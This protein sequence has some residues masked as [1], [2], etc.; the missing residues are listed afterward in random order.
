MRVLIPL[1]GIGLGTLTTAPAGAG[2]DYIVEAENRGQR[3]PV[4]VGTVIAQGIRDGDVCRFDDGFTVDVL[5]QGST[6]ELDVVTRV[7]DDRAVVVSSS[8][9]PRRV[10]MLMHDG[11]AVEPPPES[12]PGSRFR[13]RRSQRRHTV[14]GERCKDEPSF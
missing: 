13:N 1:I 10:Q 8:A 4:N 7:S 9:L 11:D 3:I 6:D 12:S 2:P 14:R 5:L